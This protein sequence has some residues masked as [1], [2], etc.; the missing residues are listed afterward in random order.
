MAVRV[1]GAFRRRSACSADAD[2]VEVHVGGPGAALA[3][4]VV[5]RADRQA[6]R[7]RRRPGTR[8]CPC[9]AGASGSVRAKTMKTSATGALVM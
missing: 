1:A 5:P 9:S 4:L 2:V 7:A 8:R 3:H 6:G